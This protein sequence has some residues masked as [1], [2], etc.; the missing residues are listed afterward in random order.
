MFILYFIAYITLGTLPFMF[1]LQFHQAASQELDSF[2]FR[3]EEQ[4]SLAE[5]SSQNLCPN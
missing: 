2:G 4:V 5:L 3:F 1:A